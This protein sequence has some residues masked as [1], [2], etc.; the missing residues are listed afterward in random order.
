MFLLSKTS[1][2]KADCDYNLVED[3]E[4]ETPK[5]KGIKGKERT[6]YTVNAFSWTIAIVFATLSGWLFISSK[7]KYP[8]NSFERG[9]K[10]EFGRFLLR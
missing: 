9:W 7:F 6:S 2:S 5:G 1:W 3:E 8:S 4:A 10:T